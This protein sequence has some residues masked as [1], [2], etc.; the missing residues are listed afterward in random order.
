MFYVEVYECILVFECLL[1]DEMMIVVQLEWIQVCMLCFV[2]GYYLFVKI[3][4][5]WVY[6]DV[7][8]NELWF[9]LSEEEL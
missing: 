6:F 5:G 3:D 1:F 7:V 9:L 2:L 8:M 4:E